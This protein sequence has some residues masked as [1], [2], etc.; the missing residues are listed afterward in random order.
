MQ[1]R[2]FGQMTGGD[3]LCDISSPC[4]LSLCTFSILSRMTTLCFHLWNV[5]EM[6][7]LMGFH[8]ALLLFRGE[9]NGNPAITILVFIYISVRNFSKYDFLPKG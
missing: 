6:F 5:K 7:Y 1:V 8:S 2:L 9:L 3:K 4:F